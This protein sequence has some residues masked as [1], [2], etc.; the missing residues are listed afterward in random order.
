[1]N[2][3]TVDGPAGAGKS[4]ISREIAS[5]LGYTYLDTGAMYRSAGL[6]ISRHNTPFDNEREVKVLLDSLYIRFDKGKCFIDNEDVSNLIRTPEVDRLASEVSRFPFVRRRLTEL[7]R[8]IGRQGPIVAEGRD[9]GTV[10][11]PEARYKFFLTAS[12]EE[13]AKRRVLQLEEMGQTAD[14]D[15]I[16]K[17]IKARDLA[18]SSREYAPM[19]KA[20]DAVLIDSTD[21]KKEDVVRLIISQINP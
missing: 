8:Q 13:R 4:Y 21:L 14:Y 17:R 1:M 6:Y 9:M 10:V 11:F 5:R 15:D 20:S 18:D 12:P 3:I 19:A 16:L 7:Q 2:I